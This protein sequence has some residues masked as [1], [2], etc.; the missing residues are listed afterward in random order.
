MARFVDGETVHFLMSKDGELYL[1]NEEI[2][3][4]VTAG[5]QRGSATIDHIDEKTNTIYFTS[6]FPKGVNH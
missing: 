4:K 2:V 3:N 1:T 6:L 5:S